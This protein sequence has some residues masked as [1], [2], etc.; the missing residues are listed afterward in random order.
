[1][2][3]LTKDEIHQLVLPTADWLN[4]VCSGDDLYALLYSLGG[5]GEDQEISYGDI[6]NRAQS[7]AMKAVV[8]NSDFL[9]DT[10][11]QRK[12]YRNIIESINKAKLGKI[13]VRGNYQF[14]ISDPIPQCQSALGLTVKGEIPADNV[15]SNFWNERQVQGYIDVCRSP[16]IDEHEHTPSK[17][18]NS[19]DADYW[20]Q[21]IKSGI[22]FS[23]YDTAVC[24]MEDSDFDGDIVLSTDNKY[25]IKGASKQS[26]VIMYDKKPTPSHKI[27]H[28]NFVETDIRG[29]GTAVGSFSNT[30]TI[31]E[32][33]KPLFQDEKIREELQDR[34][35]ILREIVGNEIDRIK[36]LAKP[37]LPDSWKKIEIINEDDS[38]IIKAEKYK[39]NSMVIS[40]KPYFFR[41]LYPELNKKYKQYENSYNEIS[42]C[43]FGVKFKK[44]LVK[45][46]KTEQEK[47]L[48]RRY[49]KYCPLI[50]SNCTMNLVCREF[51]DIDFNIQYDKT[52]ITCLPNF[53]NDFQLNSDTKKVFREM[54]RKYCNKKA[55]VYVNDLFENDINQKDMRFNVFDAIKEEI[56][57]DLFNLGIN[58]KEAL[59]YIYNLSRKY[60]KFNWAFAWDI[61]G[62]DILDVIP[63]KQ[64]L[65]PVES[66]NGAEYLGKHF[67]LKE[68]SSF[69]E[70]LFKEEENFEDFDDEWLN[71]IN[72][73][74]CP[75]DDFDM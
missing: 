37:N 35:K 15:Y 10:Y 46:D 52:N 21:Y 5:F 66:K 19:E 20:Y 36:G 41:Y 57:D 42:K 38:D 68:I 14:C 8:K 56:K 25:F 51:E 34:K 72:L 6:Y 29:F 53:E 59:A 67:L 32:T 47:K 24:R 22:I 45:Q 40:K 62:D 11:V 65:V 74:N 61:L 17:L 69:G 49:Q 75:F 54:Y 60:N 50:T 48:V 1:M 12:I 7:L 63:Q 18:Y 70:S 2:L 9:K 55:I 16:M 44:L 30:A 28:R 73:D 23:I 26:N 43:I 39:R 71:D 4:K 13:W 33:M 64:T 3:N 58:T 31:I 27:N